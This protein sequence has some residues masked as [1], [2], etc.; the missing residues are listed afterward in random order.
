MAGEAA[1]KTVGFLAVGASQLYQSLGCKGVVVLDRGCCENACK[2]VVFSRDIVEH[3]DCF[4]DEAVSVVLCAPSY[5][6]RNHYV[7]DNRHE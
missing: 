5:L 4:G 3:I 2:A 7:D 1:A 6:Y